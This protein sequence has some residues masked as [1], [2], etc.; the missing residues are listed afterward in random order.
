MGILRFILALSVVFAH[1]GIRWPIAPDR[2][3]QAFFVISG[4]YMALVLDKRYSDNWT[5]WTNRLIRIFPSYL[6]IAALTALWLWRFWPQFYASLSTFDAVTN[7]VIVGQDISTYRGGGLFLPQA[8][9]V[10]LELYFYVLAPWLVRLRSP[11]IIGLIIISIIARLI[12]Y[13][14]GLGDFWS[15]RFFPFE[16][17]FF[18]AGILIYRSGFMRISNKD[19]F[20]GELSYPIYLNHIFLARIFS[21]P[22]IVVAL[23]IVLATV[24]VFA[25]ERPLDR[26]RARRVRSSQP[27]LVASLAQP[28]TAPSRAR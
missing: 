7:V 2:A 22:W 19:Q 24:M 26:I 17:S 11:K 4:F 16:M 14:R 15:Y 23:S 6:L 25:L 20:L 10:S 5:F 28:S 12:G 9:S 8:W 1:V 27:T 18:L 21:T 13:S 3:V